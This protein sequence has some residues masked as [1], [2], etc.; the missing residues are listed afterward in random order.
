MAPRQETAPP[1]TRAMACGRSA[2]SRA[3]EVRVG[4]ISWAV[5]V[6]LATV[7]PVS[8]L[9][10]FPFSVFFVF[11]FFPFPSLSFFSRLLSFAS[12]FFLLPFS[13]LSFVYYLSFPFLTFPRADGSLDCAWIWVLFALS[14]RGDT[15][16]VPGSNPTG[17]REYQ[18]PGGCKSEG[19]MV[20]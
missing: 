19:S 12:F 4:G 2:R 16:S 17:E 3:E 8:P 1:A 11:L 9:L 18:Y 7:F 10:L 6:V 14:G 13:F 15:V 5:F 20:R